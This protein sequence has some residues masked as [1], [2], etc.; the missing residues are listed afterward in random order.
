MKLIRVGQ[1]G[2][3]VPVV[4]LD[5]QVFLDA[6]SVTDDY[7]P[8]FFSSGG[9]DDLRAAVKEAALPAVEVT[10]QRVGAPVARPTAV[11]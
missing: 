10:G 1:R 3:E 11:I 6:R 8:E 2:R 4:S 7:H 9:L 5:G